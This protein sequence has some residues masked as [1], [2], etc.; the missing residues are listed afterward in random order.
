MGI[1]PIVLTNGASLSLPLSSLTVGFRPFRFAVFRD[2]LASSTSISITGPLLMEM[3][4]GTFSPK[5]STSI[6]SY[7]LSTFLSSAFDIFEGRT[8]LLRLDA[9]DEPMSSPRRQRQIVLHSALKS[10]GQAMK[11]KAEGAVIG[12]PTKKN[13]K[14][15]LSAAEVSH[16]PLVAF[17]LAKG[18]SSSE[19]DIV[20]RIDDSTLVGVVLAQEEE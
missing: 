14:S 5:W 6:S 4:C 7:S 1:K 13:R 12:I 2:P 19:E 11:C 9:G 16:I 8:G 15:G 3:P 18:T 20:V 17:L 10:S